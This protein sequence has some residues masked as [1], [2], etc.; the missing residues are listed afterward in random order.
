[1][2]DQ[3]E[4]LYLTPDDVCELYDQLKHIVTEQEFVLDYDTYLNVASRLKDLRERIHFCPEQNKRYFRSI[5]DDRDRY[6]YRRVQN[7]PDGE[8]T[9]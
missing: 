2:P 7:M 9:E 3:Y 1:M 6:S 4:S 5:L 8:E